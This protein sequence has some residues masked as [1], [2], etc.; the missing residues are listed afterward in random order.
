[1]LIGMCAALCAMASGD[2]GLAEAAKKFAGSTNYTFKV[3]LKAEGAGGKGGGAGGTF[4]GVSDGTNPVHVTGNGVEAYVQSGK[5]VYQKDGKWTRLEPPQK[6]QKP[7]KGMREILVLR[8]IRIPHEEIAGI[9]TKLRDVKS[10]KDGDN[11]VHAGQLSEEAARD[12]VSALRRA[13]KDFTCTG[14]AKVWVDAGGNIVKYEIMANMKG[15]TKGK[16][17]GAGKEID[18][19]VTRTVE[20]SAVG[21]TAKIEVPKEATDE[22]SK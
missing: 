21:S 11:T 10:E 18:I 13:G 22:L 5:I 7:E 16:D 8:G 9:D 14:S 12:F 17:G 15:S 20:I 19:T 3:T 4:D 6:G 2:D 1:M